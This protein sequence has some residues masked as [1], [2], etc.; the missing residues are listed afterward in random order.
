MPWAAFEITR[1]SAM[2][3]GTLV[4]VLSAHCLVAVDQFMSNGVPGV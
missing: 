2:G 4:S 1:D 3:R